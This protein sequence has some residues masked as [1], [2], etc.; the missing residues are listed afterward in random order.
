LRNVETRSTRE[1]RSKISEEKVRSE[2]HQAEEEIIRE[3]AVKLDADDGYH[4][5]INSPSYTLWPF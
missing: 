5:A 3:D 4:G 1:L 2:E